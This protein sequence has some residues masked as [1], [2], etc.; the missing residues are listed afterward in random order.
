MTNLRLE[1]IAALLAWGFT[2]RQAQV[3]ETLIAAGEVGATHAQISS[4]MSIQG[5]CA[6]L[7]QVQDTILRTRRHLQ[8]IDWPGHIATVHGS[9]YRVVL[10]FGFAIPKAPEKRPRNAGAER[11]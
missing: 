4:S 9:G 8:A 11:A 1:N 7:V 6:T 10:P 5:S 3:L 2:R